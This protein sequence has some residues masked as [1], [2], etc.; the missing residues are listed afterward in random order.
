MIGSNIAAA[1][2]KTHETNINGLFFRAFANTRQSSLDGLTGRGGAYSSASKPRPSS[3]ETNLRKL[4]AGADGMARPGSALGLLQGNTK[5][6][7]WPQKEFIHTLKSYLNS[8]TFR[9]T[10]FSPY[11]HTTPTTLSRNDYGSDQFSHVFIYYHDLYQVNR[12]FCQ[13]EL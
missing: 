6:E 12:G 4:A 3:S 10:C 8:W 9:A 5:S 7:R 1:K 11:I 13:W 2:K